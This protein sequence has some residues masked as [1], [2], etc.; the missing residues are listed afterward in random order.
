MDSNPASEVGTLTHGGGDPPVK[1][2]RPASR[3]P[4]GPMDLTPTGFRVAATPPFAC[5]G[6]GAQTAAAR[7]TRASHHDRALS[8][9]NPETRATTSNGTY[10]RPGPS[11]CSKTSTRRRRPTPSPRPAVPRRPNARRAPSAPP[12]A[13]PAT[14]PPACSTSSRAA[15][16]TRSAT[17]HRRRLHATVRTDRAAH[18][19]AR[20]HRGHPQLHVATNQTPRTA[21]KRRWHLR[22]SPPYAR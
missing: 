16:A 13:G 2:P 5:S 7:T 14:P 3:A 20:P 4:R 1:G 17:R 9:E 10:A 22:S 15:P 19:R 6:S 8:P 18:T 12:T 11:C 21:P